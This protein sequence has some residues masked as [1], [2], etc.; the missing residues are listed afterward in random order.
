MMILQQTRGL[1]S[2]NDQLALDLPFAETKSLAA[3]IGPT[4]TFTR[5]S[6]A[7]YVASDGLLH[8][9]D[10]STTSNTIGTGSKSFTLT[11]TPGQDQLY[12]TGDA[13]DASNGSNSMVGTVTSY[14]PST[15]VLVCNI[16]S[17]TGSGTFTSWRI[18]Y[19]GPR[20]DHNPANPTICR[21]LLIEEGRTNLALRSEDFGTTWTNDSGAVTITTNVETSPDGSTS[22]DKIAEAASTINRRICIQNISVTS[23]TTYSYSCYI[24]AG[25]RDF[26]QL[27]AGSGL[28]SAFQN[29]VVNGAGAGT[30]GSSSGIVS[31]RIDEMPNGWYRCTMVVT[32]TATGATTIT[33]GPAPSSTLT[34]WQAYTSTAG[35]G[36]FA[37]GAQL[38][39]GSFPTSYI[40][41]TTSALARSA[42]VCSIT[43]ADFDSFYNNN[44]GTFLTDA[45]AIGFTTSNNGIVR[46]AGAFVLINRVAQ[47]NRLSASVFG[48]TTTAPSN[49]NTAGAFYQSALSAD[50][51]G[52]DFVIDGTQITDAFTGGSLTPTSSLLTFNDIPGAR[53][54]TWIKS[55]RY[56]RKMLPVSKLQALTA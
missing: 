6:G 8:G 31:S 9:V 43:G 53:C 35:S 2:S 15:Q 5:G 39:A 27:A 37:W 21:G 44:Q 41:T 16:T 4:P 20:F 55:F 51:S 40:P 42:D 14:T 3:R 17:V 33:V 12:R 34:R 48:Q 45:A 32:A 23:G 38:E 22:A 36:I 11:A 49:Y 1:L 25:E 28:N 18:G 29:F 56:Y 46:I 50:T 7:T 54:N 26:A 13:V 52:A 47:G 19:R 24:K 10:T 30:L